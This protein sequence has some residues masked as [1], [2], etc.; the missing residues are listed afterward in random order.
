MTTKIEDSPS[1]F[2]LLLS[3]IPTVIT[4]NTVITIRYSYV[5]LSVKNF[6]IVVIA[7]V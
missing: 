6:N 5:V 7:I 2:T 3:N 1:F 4:V